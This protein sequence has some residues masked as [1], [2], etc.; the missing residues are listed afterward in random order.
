[1]NNYIEIFENI[2]QCF[3]ELWSFKMRSDET[4]E[5][6]TPYSTTSNKFV[7]LFLA[8][9]SGK[10]VVSDGGLLSSESYDSIV[11]YEN[12]CLLKILYH[13]ESYYQVK[14]MIDKRGYK[15]F[16]KTTEDKNLIPNLIYDMGQ[17]IAM[18]VSSAT[19]QF[20][21]QKEKEDKETFRK[22][23]NSYLESIFEKGITKFG[24]YLDKE[25]YR[26]IRFNA[27]I[28]KRNRISLI[29]Y[30]TGSNVTNFA[31]SI[32]KTNMNFEI[33]ATSHYQ[34]IIDNKIVLMNDFADGYEP[35][36]LYK[37]IEILKNQI[38]IEPIKWSNK[39]DLLTHFN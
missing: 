33:A 24:G 3:N 20:D 12:Q 26:T 17:F 5:I 6:I 22:N 21:D 8:N 28:T 27:I 29:S 23:A 18:C 38:N 11:D 19:V 10:F 30:V 37:Q 32:A 14:S 7:S 36:K 9:K 16:Y 2:K 15:Q 35:Q 34:S 1:M 4:I 25:A 31:S 39:S 13:F